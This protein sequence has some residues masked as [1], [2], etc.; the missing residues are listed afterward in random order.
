MIMPRSPAMTILSSRN[1]SRTTLTIWVNAPGSPVFGGQHP[2]RGRA[3]FGVGEQPVVDLQLAFVGV[4]GVAAGGQRA[5]PAL[6]P[7]AGQVKQRHRRRV[8]L[9]PQVT[10]GQ[11]PHDRVLAVL[12]PVHRRVDA[13]GGGTGDAQAAPSVVSLHQVSVDSLEAGATTREMTSPS[14]RS[15]CGQA[16]PGSAGRPSLAAIACTAATCPCGSDRVIL[17][18]SAAGTRAVPFSAASIASTVCAGS[19]DRFA[20]VLWRTLPPSR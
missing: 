15:R 14:A 20:S 13:V 5:V 2:D 11:F 10:A 18:A 9:R 8:R 19:P 4:R 12:Q 7:R 6:Q 3:A 16:G 1:F 17:T